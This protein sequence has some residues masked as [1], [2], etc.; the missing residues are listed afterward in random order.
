M[1][2]SDKVGEEEIEIAEININRIQ[3]VQERVDTLNQIIED[4][5]DQEQSREQ[6]HPFKNFISPNNWMITNSR[7]QHK[8]P[9]DIDHEPQCASFRHL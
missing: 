1:A 5:M 4:S 3:N 6:L 7:N 8:S 9:L 2:N